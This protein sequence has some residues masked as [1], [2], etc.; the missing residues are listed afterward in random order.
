[1][2][3]FMIMFAVFNTNIPGFWG[4]G[5]FQ[6]HLRAFKSESFPYFQDWT[7]IISF[8]V[9]VKYSVSIFST[10][11]FEIPHKISYQYIERY[12]VYRYV[13][14][15]ALLDFLFENINEHRID[16]SCS[17]YIK[18]GPWILFTVFRKKLWYPSIW[19]EI[20]WSF[21]YS[22]SQTWSE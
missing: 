19:N 3:L 2:K 14:I 20:G 9:W 8:N 10:V 22:T 11:S 13:K 17:M 12:V 6:K 16:L 4:W 21:S 1:M 5:A 15:Y 7:T 18:G